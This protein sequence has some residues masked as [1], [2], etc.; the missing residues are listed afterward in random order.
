MGLQAW[1]WATV[2]LRVRAVVKV[3]DMV[4]SRGG[5]NVRCKL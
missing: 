5:D 4:R 3:S 1:V 2:R